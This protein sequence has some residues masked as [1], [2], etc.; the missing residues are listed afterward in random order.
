M[1]HA[2]RKRFA[3]GDTNGPDI[4]N[5]QLTFWRLAC[6]RFS[7]IKLHWQDSVVARAGEDDPDYTE[8][9]FKVDAATTIVLAGTSIS[10][11]IGQN[12]STDRTGRTPSP[13]EGLTQLLGEGVPPGAD[14]LIAIYDDLRHFGPAKHTAVWDLTEDL[15][16]E[17]LR[18]AQQI[19]GAVLAHQGQPITSEFRQPFSLD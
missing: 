19:W 18:T 5:L 8:N 4:S 11:L 14:A 1:S 12:V 9:E 7:M 3:F 2:G 16:C 6:E 17:H 13:R 10:E 15:L